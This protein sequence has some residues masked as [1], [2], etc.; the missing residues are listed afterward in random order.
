MKEWQRVLSSESP[1]QTGEGVG[2]RRQT[3]VLGTQAKQT[4]ASLPFQTA[5]GVADLHS[6]GRRSQLPPFPRLPCG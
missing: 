2:Q 5:Q 6:P 3:P 4:T 1:R